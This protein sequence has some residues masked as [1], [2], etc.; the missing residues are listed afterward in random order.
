MLC[1]SCGKNEANFHYTKIVDGGIEKKHL[2]EKCASDNYDFDFDK[3]FSMNKFFTGL[4]DSIQE[5]QRDYTEMKCGYC[6]QTYS[7]F[8]RNGKFGCI[9]CYETFKDK[10]NPLIRGL[11]GHNIHRGKIPKG[12][13]ERIFLKREEDNLKIQLEKAVKEEEFEK[14][15]IIRDKLRELKIKLDSYGSD[16]YD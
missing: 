12:S 13:N 5:T 14:A 7:E 15:A 1:D 3:P 4:I 11:H 8:K 2:C 9:Q 6:G 16:K 10:L